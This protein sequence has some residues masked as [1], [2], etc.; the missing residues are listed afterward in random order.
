VV[1]RGH[2]SRDLAY[3]LIIGMTTDERMVNQRE[4][5]DVYR[6]AL[7][8][9]SG[10]EFDREE[11][12][13]RYR[14][15]AVQPYLASLATAGLGGMQSDEIVFEGLRRAVAAFDDLD[16]VSLLHRSL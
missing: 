5:L 9:A 7:A 8:S 14:Q 1:K 2:P 4:L 16:T 3:S 12:W 11:L 10:P 15:A 13:D 6:Q